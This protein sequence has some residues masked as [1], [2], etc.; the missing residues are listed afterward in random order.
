[1]TVDAVFFNRD[2]KHLCCAGTVDIATVSENLHPPL[3]MRHPCDDP[4]FDGRKVR[5]DEFP[6][7][8]RNESGADQ[9]GEHIRD[10]I[11]Q[12]VQR[13]IVSNAHQIACLLQVRH[14]ILRKILQLN[15]PA[16]KSSC[17]IGSVEHE[18][19]V[20]T[21]VFAD[22]VLHGLIFLHGAFCKLPAE[23]KRLSKLI[24][25]V[26]QQGGHFLFAK[27]FDLHAM[28]GKPSLHLGDGVWILKGCKRVHPLGQFSPGQGIHSDG[29]FHELHVQSDPTIV[30]LLIQMVLVP[31]K[32]RHREAGQFLLDR[33]LC[34]NVAQVIAFEHGPLVRCVGWT[35]PCSAAVRFCWRTRLAEET[36][37]IFAC[38]QL[39]FFEPEHS[40]H[41]GEGKRETEI[42]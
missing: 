11:V 33:H 13:I 24:G 41:A 31:D 2:A 18:H 5:N 10:G 29:V 37:Q 7:L 12:G 32:I 3:L 42:S 9:L 6:A 30:D 39:L 40:A 35:I 23:E 34:F 16:R 26:L 17:P 4:G 14:V 19:A 22:A 1:M 20:C 38:F 8:I 28:L 36:D 25:S 15:Q 27:R 21:P